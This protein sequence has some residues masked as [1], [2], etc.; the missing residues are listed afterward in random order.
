[1]FDPTIYENL[2]VVVEGEI[3]ERDLNGEIVIIDRQDCV[4][5]ATM[6]R[7]YAIT[8]QLL[9]T[10]PLYKATIRLEA[11]SA[12]LYGEILENE[13]HPG[14][15]LLLSVRG[16][17]K[18]VEVLPASFQDRLASLWDNRPKISQ[19]ISFDWNKNKQPQYYLSTTLQF[20]RKINESHISDF[21]EI[22]SLL[23]GSL[24][25]FEEI[26]E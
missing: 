1:M 4:N 16:P 21:P 26:N 19:Q 6:S 15:N 3:Y 11:E 9:G 25:L 2:K 13:K 14:C 17:I 8:F 24:E 23:Q 12:D 7:Y 18:E 20:D 22:I 10:S 5:L